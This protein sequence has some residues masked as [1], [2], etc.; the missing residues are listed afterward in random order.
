MSFVVE[1]WQFLR[2]RRKFWLLP[3]CIVLGVFGVVLV[4]SEISAVAPLIYTLF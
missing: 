2:S 3:L 4:L 1:F